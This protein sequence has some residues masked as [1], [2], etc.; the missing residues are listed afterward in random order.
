[1][2]FGSIGFFPDFCR[3]VLT[4]LADLPVRVSLTLGEAGDPEQLGPLPSNVHVERWW[5]QE[6]IVPH[7]AAMV[8][9]GGF[10]TTLFGLSAGIPTVVVPLFAWDQYATARRIQAL[11]A[12]VSLDD[13][14]AAPLRVR[15]ALELVFND[16]TYRVAARRVADE[17]ARLP[18]PSTCVA[19]LEALVTNRVETPT[20]H[21]ASAQPSPGGT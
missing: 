17:I 16:S 7:A 18:D 13:G 8:T 1:V 14:P 3:A 9:H 2:T 19:V 6:Q 12:G 15:D 11:G 5:P 10:G 20:D 4:A 21:G